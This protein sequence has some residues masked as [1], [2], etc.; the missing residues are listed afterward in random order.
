M[1]YYRKNSDPL[2]ALGEDQIKAGE[3][4]YNELGFCVKKVYIDD[5]IYFIEVVESVLNEGE[6]VSKLTKRQLELFWTLSKTKLKEHE[7]KN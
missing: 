5:T 2:I 6:L 1:K 3:I 4:V 7:D